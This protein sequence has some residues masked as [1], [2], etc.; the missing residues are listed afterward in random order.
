MLLAHSSS[1]MPIRPPLIP[2]SLQLQ[3]RPRPKDPSLSL[4]LFQSPRPPCASPRHSPA[5]ISHR[6]IS[7]QR[8]K[9]SP[10]RCPSPSPQL[11]LPVC[12]KNGFYGAAVS[13]SCECLLDRS[14]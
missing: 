3:P 5:P 14:V 12:A 10:L 7:F 11:Y 8:T 9:L 4:E 13:D 1:P 6:E 2:P